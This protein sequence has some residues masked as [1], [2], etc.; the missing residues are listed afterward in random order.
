MYCFGSGSEVP[1][2]TQTVANFCN[3]QFFLIFPLLFFGWGY[4]SRLWNADGPE[5]FPLS[6]RTLYPI[7]G[8]FEKFGPP[9]TQPFYRLLTRGFKRNKHDISTLNRSSHPL[10]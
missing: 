9:Y 4:F 2:P 6:S 1:D 7:F 5:E 8:L 3:F 10:D